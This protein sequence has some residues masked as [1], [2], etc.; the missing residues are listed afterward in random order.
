MGM[1][2]TALWS[3]FRARPAWINPPTGDTLVVDRRDSWNASR[4]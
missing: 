4:T 1:P 3:K 2:G